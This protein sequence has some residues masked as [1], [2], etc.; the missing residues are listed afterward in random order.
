MTW[1]FIGPNIL[2]GIGQVTRKYANL[3]KGEYVEFHQQPQKTE[4]DYGFVFMLPIEH[5]LK[6][7]DEIT[8]RCRKCYY[9]T[10][11]E[12]ETVNPLYG[13]LAKYKPLYVP[14]EFCKNVLERQFP[15]MHC[16][17]LRHHTP[18]ARTPLTPTTSTYN[19]YTICNALDPRKNI[20]MLVS[21]FSQC[22]FPGARLVIKSTANN[23]LSLDTPNVMVIN[24]LITDDQMEKIHGGCHCYV[25]CS[26]SE[27]V[28]MGAVEA[29][30]RGKPVIITNYGG[31]KEYVKTPWIVP[32]KL[33]KI[34]FDDFL[35]TRDMEWGHPHYPTLVKHL[36]DC[37]T[38][39]VV[40]FDHRH[41]REIMNQVQ[42][43]LQTLG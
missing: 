9:M 42:I 33:G 7:I 20:K 30:M 17:I 28:G 41:T 19:F 34:G 32:C 16:K 14:S 3:V 12:T 21:A 6:Q 23:P 4:Y 8:K 5:Q 1:L 35:F 15:D 40:E 26:H 37:Y 29:A 25:N 27:G 38:S 2:S 13:I 36:T 39:R 24:G 43:D 11:C 22:N 31:L 10:V 18:P